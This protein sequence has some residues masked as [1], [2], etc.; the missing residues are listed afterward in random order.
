MAT[1]DGLTIPING[2]NRNFR[3]TLGETKGMLSGTLPIAAGTVGGLLGGK[4]MLDAVNH[5][6]KYTD[7]IM[8]LSVQSG[9]S[10]QTIQELNEV[11]SRQGL[12]LSQTMPLLDQMQKKLHEAS[13]GTGEAVKALRLLGMSADD[14]KGKNVADQFYMITKA[15]EGLSAQDQRIVAMN[16]FGE[17]GARMIRVMGQGM[18]EINKQ[19]E[20]ALRISEA[21]LVAIKSFNNELSVMST[22]IE[23]IGAKHLGPAFEFFNNVTGITKGDPLRNPEAIK[24]AME[25]Q[26]PALTLLNSIIGDKLDKGVEKVVGAILGE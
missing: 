1:S 25:V 10:V 17:S 24:R 18:D 12:N 2:D 6:R 23:A 22:R 21:D 26:S 9:L 11:F 15:M 20:A 3:R 16:L 5:I 4:M 8:D 19:R 14:F 13:L 7:N